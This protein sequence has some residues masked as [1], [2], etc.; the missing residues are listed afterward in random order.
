M[1]LSSSEKQAHAYCLYLPPVEEACVH[2]VMPF[3]CDEFHPAKAQI[4]TSKHL[5]LYTA[6]N[7]SP[8][9]KDTCPY[10]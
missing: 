4:D 6:R 2:A 10:H 7:E 1:I 5:N 3:S 9:P 8:A